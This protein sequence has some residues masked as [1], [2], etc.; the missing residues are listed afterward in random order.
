ML[1]ITFEQ[2][3]KSFFGETATAPY[4]YYGGVCSTV[5]IDEN[6]HAQSFTLPFNIEP[7]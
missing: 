2:K 5:F 7:R 1:D 3:T 6:G 4:G